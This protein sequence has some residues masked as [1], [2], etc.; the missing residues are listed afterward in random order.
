MAATLAE[1][2][3][4]EV[5]ALAA[6]RREPAWLAERRKSAWERFVNGPRPDRVSHLWR[7]TEPKY[8]E[9]AEAAAPAP[10]RVVPL[11]AHVEEGLDR[12]ELEAAIAIGAAGVSEV[13]LS[14]AA[15]EAGVVLLDLHA[16][17]GDVRHEPRVREQLGRLVG[18]DHGRYE[19]YNTALWSGGA[20]LH[21]PRNVRL[22]APIHVSLVAAA[23]STYQ[24]P[25]LLALVDENAEVTLVEEHLGGHAE[26][27]LSHAVSE[28]VVGAGSRVRYVMA[29]RLDAG[30]N[31]HGTQ[32][33]ELGRDADLFMLLTSF[34]GHVSKLDSGVVLAG[35][36]SRTRI[37][38]FLFGEKRQ[39]FDHHTVLDH[40]ADHTFSDL[41]FKTVLADRARSAYTGLIR[42][43]RKAPY[44]E[45]YQENRNLL[46]SEQARAESIPELEISVDE[47]QC[48]HGA[49]V[50]PVDPEPLFY[51]MS[52]GIP[53]G[54]AIRQV[55]AGFLEPTL[56][57]IPEELAKP[58][59]RELEQRLAKIEDP[60]S[61]A[62]GRTQ[63]R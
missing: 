14:N 23:D 11:P 7:Y 36:G 5:Q 13:R 54:E 48:K 59:R 16:A 42:I 10:P 2:G 41:D 25:R 30:V 51:L 29:Q 1:D 15:R 49:T 34:G 4:G 18:A 60:A 27:S 50:G 12:G 43:P 9:P 28:V 17:A 46:L 20:Y 38:G 44:S 62:A 33:I 52:R 61:A 53:R 32:R 22:T 40:G 8:F 19:S 58:L 31:H 3:M 37:L 47:V 26:H 55:V 45:A 39:H 57:E 24:A 21:V 35:R 56:V 63:G 6:A